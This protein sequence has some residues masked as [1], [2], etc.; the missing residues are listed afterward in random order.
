MKGVF[1]M[2]KVAKRS[3]A[4]SVPTGKARTLPR[5][6]SLHLT[7]RLLLVVSLILIGVFTSIL[8]TSQTA[9]LYSKVHKFN[10]ETDRIHEN[11]K[12]LETRYSILITKLGVK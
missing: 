5:T 3:I 11:I 1:L 9:L 12:N 8:I 2:A 10:Q 7:I 6:R 4:V